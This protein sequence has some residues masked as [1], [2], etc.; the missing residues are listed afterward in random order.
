MRVGEALVGEVL[1]QEPVALLE[2]LGLRMV[3]GIAVGHALHGVA[4]VEVE[5]FGFGD[6][7]RQRLAVEH[8][9][10]ADGLQH[11]CV[12]HIH[13]RAEHI[14]S[15]ILSLFRLNMEVVAA[16]HRLLAF[17]ADEHAEMGLVG[18]F[19]GREARVAVEAIGA[20]LQGQAFA[21]VVEFLHAVDDLFGQGIEVGLSLLIFFLVLLEPRAV[22]VVEH[23]FQKCYDFFHRVKISAKIVKNMAGNHYFCS[24]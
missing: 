3:L 22:V 2:E 5:T 7:F 16:Q 12:G 24:G 14:M 6:A 4:G 19:V 18:S 17:G 15:Q 1:H 23:G 9:F 10:V 20:V 21:V 8:D 13:S 11:G